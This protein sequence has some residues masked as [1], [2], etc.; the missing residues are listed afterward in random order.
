M[1]T[2]LF[3]TRTFTN[4]QKSAIRAAIAMS[5]ALLLFAAMTLQ[6]AF[7]QEEVRAYTGNYIL[8]ADAS[9]DVKIKLESGDA[10]IWAFTIALTYDPEIVEQTECV[11]ESF[12]GFCNSPRPGVVGISGVN[13]DGPSGNLE[14]ATINFQALGISGNSTSLTMAISTLADESGN[15]IPYTVEEGKIII[16][17]GAGGTAASRIFLPTISRSKLTLQSGET[18]ELSYN[19]IAMSW[20]CSFM[21]HFGWTSDACFI[22]LD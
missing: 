6:T 22:T 11:L 9:T 15:A 5:A 18:V 13:T 17:S 12:T 3:L 1:P 8:Q 16:G 21:Q 7:A 4:T 20:L 10:E 19:Q 14:L 2:S